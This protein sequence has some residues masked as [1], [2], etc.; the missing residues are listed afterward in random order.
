MAI[1]CAVMFLGVKGNAF[2]Y[3]KITGTNATGANISGYAS[4]I[5]VNVADIGA[6]P[7]GYKDSSDA[8]QKALDY[9]LNSGSNKVQVKVYLP[10]GTYYINKTLWIHSNTWIFMDDGARIV[11]NFNSGCMMRNSLKSGKGGYDGDKNIIIQGGC[12]DGNVSEST[13]TFSC[14]RFAHITNL[15]IKDVEFKDNKNGHHLEIGGTKNLTIE[16]CDFHGYSGSQQKEAI[17]LDVMNNKNIFPSFEPFDDTPCDNS[18][19]RNNNFHDLMRG[20]GSHSATVGVYYTNTLISGNTFKNLKSTAIVMVNHKNCI[21]E[22]NTMQNVGYG[23]DFKYMTPKEANNFHVPVNGYG[24]VYQKLDD[25]A[26]LVIRNN[27]ISTAVTGLISEP[28]AIQLYGR[29]LKG[30]ARPDYNYEIKGVKI[31]GND[32]STVGQAFLLN[33]ASE[34]LISSNT[35]SYDSTRLHINNVDLISASSGSDI[36]INHN[37]VM[38]SPKNGIS[39]NG[40]KNIN[41]LRNIVNNSGNSA[42]MISGKDLNAEI[43]TNK[44]SGSGSNGIK[45]NSGVT[46][47]LISNIVKKSGGNGIM[48]ESASG[49]LRNNISRENTLSGFFAKASNIETRSNLFNNNGEAGMEL[50][51]KSQVRSVKNGS[52]G[53]AKGKNSVY[54]ESELILERVT[55]IIGTNNKGGGIKISWN[56]ISQADGY[57]IYRKDKS[58]GEYVTLGEVNMPFYIDLDS[59]K[60]RYTYIIKA[61]IKT[62]KG[63][64]YGEE[65]EETEI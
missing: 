15:W 30:G 51:R 56:D 14:V 32:I 17:Q 27:K 28:F 2:D 60:G 53:N 41:I 54:G 4:A 9:A 13:G 45:I 35:V 63:N 57:E 47:D 7:T 65:S 64:I 36:T 6:D 18:I 10:K 24:D 3:S 21:I 1:F 8:I 11:R 33:D 12:I 49:T 59:Q 22:G 58:T 19:I 48:F 52:D 29:N 37:S 62:E 39:I 23:V 20:I 31:C 38:G 44:I 43:K 16:G 50:S 42:I 46:A 25:Y 26:N 34:V 5:Q 40:G 61:F 55:D